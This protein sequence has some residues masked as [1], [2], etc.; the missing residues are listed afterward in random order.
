MKNRTISEHNDAP[1]RAINASLDTE[2]FGTLREA[3]HKAHQLFAAHDILTGH[4][5][6]MPTQYKVSIVED[7]D[8]NKESAMR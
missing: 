2:F 8:S 5:E 4:V 3:A 1:L 6:I 7:T